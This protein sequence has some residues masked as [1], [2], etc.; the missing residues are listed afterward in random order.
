MRIKI[1][2][3]YDGKEQQ[4]LSVLENIVVFY[5]TFGDPAS[6]G[7]G[8]WT[9]GVIWYEGVQLDVCPGLL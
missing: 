4:A 6:I 7:I 5:E 1:L 3:S 9:G 8:F 2:L